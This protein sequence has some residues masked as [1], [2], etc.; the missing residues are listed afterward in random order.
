MRLLSFYRQVEC[1]GDSHLYKELYTRSSRKVKAKLLCD[2]FSPFMCV[3][4]DTIIFDHV[5][6]V[7]KIKWLESVY[8]FYYFFSKRYT[9]K[10]AFFENTTEKLS[11]VSEKLKAFSSNGCSWNLQFWAPFQIPPLALW[12]A[13]SLEEPSSNP[14]P[15]KTHQIQSL[16]ESAQNHTYKLFKTW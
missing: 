14:V 9:C 7:F 16:L 13:S 2:P 3:H 15:E 5:K 10:V 11:H 6:A 4:P 1:Q 12:V 8:N